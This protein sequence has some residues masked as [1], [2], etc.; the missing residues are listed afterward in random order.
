VEKAAAGTRMD[1]AKQGNYRRF[2]LALPPAPSSVPP[3]VPRSNACVDPSVHGYP[4]LAGEYARG[5]DDI[6]DLLKLQS[7]QHTVVGNGACGVPARSGGVR[8]LRR[9]RGRRSRWRARVC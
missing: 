9:G 3:A 1:A 8:G 4:H 6:V 5:V 2:T 7:C